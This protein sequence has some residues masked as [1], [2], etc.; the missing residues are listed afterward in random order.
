MRPI[1][2]CGSRS[3]RSQCR[4]TLETLATIKTPPAVA[5]VKQF[6]NAAGQMQVNNNVR[7]S[8]AR[9]E[10]GQNE[11]LEASN[12]ERLDTGAALAPRR[13]NQAMEA[14]GAVNGAEDGGR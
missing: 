11:L 5:F 9:E 10:I 8:V 6:N 2:T 3:G 4:T 7:P 13:A 12:G 14:V 1:P